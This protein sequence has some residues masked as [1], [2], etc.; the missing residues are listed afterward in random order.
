MRNK[1]NFGA[2]WTWDRRAGQTE[3]GPACVRYIWS[4][5][6]QAEAEWQCVYLNTERRVPNKDERASGSKKAQNKANFR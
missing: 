5:E 1:A 2:A 6:S 3:K 4:E